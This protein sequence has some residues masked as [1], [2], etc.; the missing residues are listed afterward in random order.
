MIHTGE[1][2]FECTLCET[3][4]R[5]LHHLNVH[6]ESNAHRERMEQAT[7]RGEEVPEALDP[8]RRPRLRTAIE[9]DEGDD[10]AYVLIAAEDEEGL[11]EQT[12]D[13]GGGAHVVIPLDDQ[14]VE[15]VSADAVEECAVP[16]LGGEEH[17][18]IVVEDD[19]QVT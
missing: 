9:E 2:P 15:V 6:T 1:T 7:A 10:P 16:V 8:A 17:I 5:R 4:F 12:G 14:P 13:S 11:L 18:T 19:A 3:K